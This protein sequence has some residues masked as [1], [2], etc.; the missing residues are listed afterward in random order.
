MTFEE[1]IIF[2]IDEIPVPEKLS[3]E[4]IAKML[5]A[6]SK[7][8]IKTE[9][10][11]TASEIKPEITMSGGHGK[12][13][14]NAV[15]RIVAAIAACAVLASG[16]I[17]YN[18]NKAERP[19]ITPV[20]TYEAVSSPT[21]PSSYAELYSMYSALQIESTG[22]VGSKYEYNPKSAFMTGDTDIVKTDGTYL[23]MLSNG[24]VSVF[25]AATGEVV[26]TITPEEKTAAELFAEKGRIFLVLSDENGEVEAEIYDTSDITAPKLISS[27]TQKGRFISAKTENGILYIVSDYSDYRDR[28][29]GGEQ[30]LEGFVPSYSANGEELFI[31]ADDITVPA[32]AA[33]TDYTVIA[34]IADEA[35]GVK[36]ILGS[37][38]NAYLSGDSLYIYGTGKTGDYS[39]ISKYTIGD[40]L[41]Y[42][43]SASVAGL[44]SV[45][46]SL[47]EEN[48]NLRVVTSG[49]DSDGLISSNVYVLDKNMVSINSAGTLLQTEILRNVEYCGD[50]V[51]LYTDGGGSLTLDL[52]ASPPAVNTALAGV[53]G[54]Y[55]YGSDKLLSL[56]WK[57]SGSNITGFVLSM[58]NIKTGVKLFET[59]YPETEA[60]IFSA[61]SLD[62]RAVLISPKDNVIGIPI[63]SFTEFGTKNSYCI[64]S[65]SETDGFTLGGVIEYTD[66]DDANIF[67]RGNIAGGY[68]NISGGGRIIQ[69]TLGDRKVREVY[70][71]D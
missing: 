62:K 41:R 29:L 1:K 14:Q 56:T 55:P 20:L 3:P 60:T 28:P 35:V 27:Y 71:L 63:Y 31:P 15:V 48:D 4:N 5:K 69:V 65:F 36:A 53:S 59:A 9:K 12:E 17:V 42:I 52:S 54:I 51:F 33:S 2:S 13:T 11:E 10:S 70:Q 22:N 23:F 19:E 32:N 61:A 37:G 30:D 49:F 66:I 21:V 24:K 39:I 6:Q 26:S 58:Y 8:V 44:V 25:D 18:T 68:L 64:Y 40:G 43:D 67:T 38:K 47:D 46:G 45:P 7:A 50:L 16:L 34:A 57:E